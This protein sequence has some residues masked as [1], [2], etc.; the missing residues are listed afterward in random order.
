MNETNSFYLRFILIQNT[1]A[2]PEWGEDGAH[3]SNMSRKRKA[4]VGDIYFMFFLSP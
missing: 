2:D 4:V 1:V 3:G